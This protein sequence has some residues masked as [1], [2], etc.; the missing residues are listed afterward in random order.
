MK[1]QDI[2]EENVPEPAKKL[3]HNQKRKLNVIARNGIKR[4]RTKT[5]VKEVTLLK[6][7]ERNVEFDKIAK[8]IEFD[9]GKVTLFRQIRY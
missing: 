4:L 6:E 5:K 1:M 3:S 9:H 2:K 8:K 7:M